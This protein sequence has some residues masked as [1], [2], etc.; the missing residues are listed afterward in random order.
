MA[1]SRRV[2]ACGVRTWPKKSKTSMPTIAATV[3]AHTQK[4]TSMQ[5]P[6]VTVSRQYRRS[7]PLPE[8]ATDRPGG[9]GPDGPDLVMTTLP[10][11]DTP[12]LCQTAT[13][14]HVAVRTVSTGWRLK[15]TRRL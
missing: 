4:G 8:P 2:G 7:L 6:P 3:T 9:L 11:G 13:S 10:R 15:T 1:D 5:E 12:L 14:A